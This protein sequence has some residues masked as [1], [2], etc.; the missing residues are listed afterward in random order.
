MTAKNTLPNPGDYVVIRVSE[1]DKPLR[2]AALKVLS[3]EKDECVGRVE[4][5]AHIRPLQVTFS[6]EHVVVNLGPKPYPGVVYGTDMTRRYLKTLDHDDFGP[7]HFFNRVN[8]ET[9]AAFWS[10]MSAVY[11]E[12]KKI[13][14]ASI[15]H[16][17]I[18]YEV[19]PQVSLGKYSGMFKLSKDSSK[20]PHRICMSV[21]DTT[22]EHV[23]IPTWF[24]VLAHELGHAAHLLWLI[25]SPQAEAAW[26]A[27]YTDTVLCETTPAKDL[28]RILK[29][30]LKSGL[31]AGDYSSGLEEDDLVSFKRA[32][33]WLKK[34]RGI[35][36][37]E[38]NLLV[39]T[40]KAESLNDLWPT[41]VSASRLE[42]SVTLYACKNY[43]ELFAEAFAFYLCGKK[44]PASIQSL[45]EKSLRLIRIQL[46]GEE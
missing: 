16:Q 41:Q 42:P 39:Q 36:V 44:L 30:F 29:D 32:L 1:V 2:T 10:A 24:Y 22:M 25:K 33:A 19:F 18:C 35:S 11:K 7:V 13:G 28:A 21:S 34:T 45:M 43:K 46:K 17:D 14:L 12:M 23:S 26:I 38:V 40:G 37:K 4:K 5:D 6:P 31:P 8:K 20:N 3:A 9:L 15:V 27:A